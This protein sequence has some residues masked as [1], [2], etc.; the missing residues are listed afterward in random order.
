MNLLRTI[1][2]RLVLEPTTDPID[3]EV[4]RRIAIACGDDEMEAWIHQPE[5]SAPEWFVLKFPGAGGRA[6][7]VGTFPAETFSDCCEVWGINPPGYGSSTGR[8]CVSK[9]PVVAEAAWEAIRSTAGNRPVLV[10]GTSLGAMYALYVAARFP[11]AGVF[12]RHAAPVHQLIRGKHD[13]WS[14]GIASKTIGRQLSSEMDA[15][16]NAKNCPA[17]VFISIAEQDKVIPPEYQFELA[18]S[19]AGSTT[20]FVLKKGRHH[21]LVDESQQEEFDHLVQTWVRQVRNQRSWL[22]DKA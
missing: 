18:R 12:I 1:A 20:Q 19:F 4:R 7:R 21:S 11:V 17:P 13:R 16:E 22:N 10:T 9:M 3:P 15:V 5:S 6:E 8:A 2:N 14:F